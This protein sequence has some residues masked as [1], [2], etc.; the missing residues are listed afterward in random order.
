MVI[1]AELDDTGGIGDWV[2]ATTYSFTE[3]AEYAAVALNGYLY[4]IGGDDVSGGA[5]SNTGT[6]SVEYAQINADGSLGAWQETEGTFNGN[7]AL[8]AAALE[9]GIVIIDGWSIWQEYA[10]QA[11]DGSLTE[12]GI[13][14]PGDYEERGRFGCVAYDGKLYVLGGYLGGSDNEL[15]DSV[16]YGDIVP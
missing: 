2:T 16:Y 12:W 11:D 8:G 7:F 14:S 1:Y 6:K 3:R 13:Y 9:D 15:L 4:V 5:Y 10:D